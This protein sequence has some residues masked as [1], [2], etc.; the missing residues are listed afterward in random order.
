MT[1][2]LRSDEK[3]VEDEG[4]HRAADR[5]AAFLESLSGRVLFWEIG[6]GF[7]TPVI[8]KYPFWRMTAENPEAIY[9]CMNQNDAFCPEAIADRSICLG[10]DCAE[11]ISF[12]CALE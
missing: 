5:Y 11:A 1:L 8:I 4:W 2:N 6:V 12:L 3:F 9:V 10:G 7:N